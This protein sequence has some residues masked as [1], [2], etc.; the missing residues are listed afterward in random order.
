MLE[1]NDDNGII[2]E[3]GIAT[4]LENILGWS[5]YHQDWLDDNSKLMETIVNNYSALRKLIHKENA[6]RTLLSIDIEDSN[7]MVLTPC[8]DHH[9]FVLNVENGDKYDAMWVELRIQDPKQIQQQIEDLVAN[10]SPT[11]LAKMIILK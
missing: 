2:T 6:S 11:E 4:I 1:V 10:H 5:E 9:T 3:T 7:A 8:D